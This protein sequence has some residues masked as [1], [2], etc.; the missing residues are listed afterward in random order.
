MERIIFPA[1]IGGAILFI[2]IFG[3]VFATGQTFGQRCTAAGWFGFEHEKCVSRLV[4]GGYV[5]E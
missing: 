1:T 3:F 2:A 4:S 5:Y